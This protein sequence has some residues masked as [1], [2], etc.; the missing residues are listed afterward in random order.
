MKKFITY[1]IPIVTLTVFVL[2]MLGGNYLKK[3]H[4]PSEDVI[5]FVNLSIKHAKVENWDK[6][7]QDIA[8]I[9]IAWKKVIPRIQFSVERDEMYNISLNLASLRGSIA[10]KDKSSTLIE[11]NEMVEN[12]DELTK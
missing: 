3:P 4:N 8:S 7:E 2:I 10:S 11:L 9:D 5:A 12:W 1:F 6:L